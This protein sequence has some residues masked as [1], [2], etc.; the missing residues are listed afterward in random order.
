MVNPPP[1]ISLS[2]SS[3]CLCDFR[4]Q[5]EK[6]SGVQAISLRM[7]KNHT[8]EIECGTT[9]AVLSCMSS[10]VFKES[11]EMAQVCKLAGWHARQ[12]KSP[13]I[14]CDASQL[15]IFTILNRYEKQ[16]HD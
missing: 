10:W 12:L 4:Q 9:C 6:S 2:L 16:R 11:A 14:A 1:H 8:H 15:Q 3:L 7:K 13:F 5:K